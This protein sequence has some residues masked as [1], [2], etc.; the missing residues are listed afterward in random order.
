MIKTQIQLP[1]ALYRAL[2]RVAEEREMSLAEVL[3]R[4]AEYIT[5]VYLPVEKDNP[6]A[7]LPGPFHAGLKRDP[8]AGPDWR[9]ELNERPTLPGVVRDSRGP[10]YGTRAGKRK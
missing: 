7:G 3:R 5:Q 2:K 1:H 10:G 4:G 9:Y 8:F 6:D